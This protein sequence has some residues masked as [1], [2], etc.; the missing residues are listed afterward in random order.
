MEVPDVESV[1]EGKGTVKARADLGPAIWSVRV[2][3]GRRPLKESRAK[4]A[5]VDRYRHELMD[6][7]E[8]L[9]LRERVKTV[10]RA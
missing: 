8:R 9:L 10:G 2:K 5:L 7:E 1:E 3:R 4:L 6:D